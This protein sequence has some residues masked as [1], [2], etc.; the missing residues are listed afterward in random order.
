[1]SKEVKA[2]LQ[3]GAACEEVSFFYKKKRDV[4]EQKMSVGVT[5]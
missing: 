1:M 4:V 5:E 3:S 2:P